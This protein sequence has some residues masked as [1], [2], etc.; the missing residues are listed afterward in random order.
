MKRL[1]FLLLVLIGSSSI[2]QT[3]DG[4]LKTVTASGTNTYAIG[5]TFPAI[6]TNKERFIVEFTNGNSGASTLNRNGLGAKAI[7]TADGSALSSGDIAAGG[8]YLLSYNGTHYRIVGSVGGGS[9]DIEV[10]VTEI[11][12]GT[13]TR[14]LYNNSGVV[15]DYSISGTGNVAMTT[16][17]TF[18]TPALGTPSAAVLTNATGLPINTG[19]T[20]LDRGS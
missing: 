3:I 15:G 5:E 12:S 18:T 7:V 17:P 11:T 14:V 6:Y 10:G 2:A 19:L 16:S 13:N 20:G 9:G 8:R 4:A 1:I